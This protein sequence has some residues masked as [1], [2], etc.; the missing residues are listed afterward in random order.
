MFRCLPAGCI[1]EWRS[2]HPQD[3]V[4]AAPRRSSGGGSSLFGGADDG[5][6][7]GGGED[8]SPLS[9]PVASFLDAGVGRSNWG[10]MGNWGLSASSGGIFNPFM[11]NP[12]ERAFQSDTL[13]TSR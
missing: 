10:Q 1:W 2:I 12:L 9:G 6:G 13:Q 8:L 4:V 5:G 7:G 3:A 11:G